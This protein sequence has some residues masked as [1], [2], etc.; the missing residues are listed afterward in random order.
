MKTRYKIYLFLLFKLNINMA[1]SFGTKITEEIT[2][3]VANRPSTLYLAKYRFLCFQKGKSN[4]KLFSQAQ[5]L[6]FILRSRGLLRTLLTICDPLSDNM[7]FFKLTRFRL[8]I[9]LFRYA[10]LIKDNFLSKYSLEYLD[11]KSYSLFD[12]YQYTQ[13]NNLFAINQ[14]KLL[15]E[16]IVDHNWTKRL[17][18]NSISKKSKDNLVLDFIVWNSYWFGRFIKLYDLVDFVSPYLRINFQLVLDQINFLKKMN[19]TVHEMS[20]FSLDDIYRK[21]GLDY[22][23]S[24]PDVEILH[25]R[26]IAVENKILNLDATA[27]PSLEFVAGVWQFI[28][29]PNEEKLECWMIQPNGS[30]VNFD[31][32]IYL[33]GRAD[34]NWFHFLLDTAPRIMFFDSVPICVPILIRGDIPETSKDFLRKITSREIIE[35]N[36]TDIVKV[37]IL[38]VMPGRSSVY[39]REPSNG[40]DWVKFPAIILGLF[41]NRVLEGKGELPQANYAPLVS[42]ERKSATRNVVNW[43]KINQVL[44]DYSFIDTPLDANFFTIQIE[45]FF[46]SKIVVSPGGAVLANII[47]MKPEGKVIVLKSFK[48]SKLAIWSKLAKACN[49][50]YIEIQGLPTYWGPYFNRNLHSNFYISPR[51]LRRILSREI[52]SRT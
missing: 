6:L 4:S 46:N 32:A 51:K 26:F 35:I 36:L 50:S 14:F 20:N 45:V 17:Y 12:K 47:F 38:Y 37:G 15:N 29:E 16:Y 11:I 25:Q 24:I 2:A 21:K 5:V 27:N 28:Q 33:I 10:K 41:R 44:V 30:V 22:C 40:E 49:L 7:N 31:R 18:I 42:F 1:N 3:C 8:S 19:I 34:D 52:C 39:D 48:Y 23:L 43:N 9:K 13:I